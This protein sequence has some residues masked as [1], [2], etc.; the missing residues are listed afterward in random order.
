M[1]C[2][3]THPHPPRIAAAILYLVRREKFRDENF[4]VDATRPTKRKHESNTLSAVLRVLSLFYHEIFSSRRSLSTTCGGKTFVSKSAVITALLFSFTARSPSLQTCRENKRCKHKCRTALTLA[5]PAAI[6]LAAVLSPKATGWRTCAHGTTSSA[7]FRA[8]MSSLAHQLL[9]V[10]S[11][12]VVP[13]ETVGDKLE[14][15]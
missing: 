14:R 10:I 11:A 6:K 2:F 5:C 3:K 12:S 9:H 1:A 15:V 13:T 7:K 8:A 4:Y